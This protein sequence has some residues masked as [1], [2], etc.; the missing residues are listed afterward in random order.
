MTAELRC[1]GCGC[2]G[3]APTL[4]WDRATADPRPIL[5]PVFG[6]HADGK[7]ALLCEA[8]RRTMAKRRR[9]R[10]RPAP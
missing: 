3:R 10:S 6:W 2:E 9:K 4:V 8:C 1:A 5:V 7:P